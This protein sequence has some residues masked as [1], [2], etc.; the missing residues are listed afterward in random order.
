MYTNQ[1]GAGLEKGYAE[2]I[3]SYTNFDTRYLYWCAQ[4]AQVGPNLVIRMQGALPR[5]PRSLYE[6][7]RV[8]EAGQY[9]ARYISISTIDMLYPSPTYQEFEDHDIERFYSQVP[10]W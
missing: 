3:T 1:P 4:K 10:N 9:D 2:S 7:P 8:A 6:Y 5:V